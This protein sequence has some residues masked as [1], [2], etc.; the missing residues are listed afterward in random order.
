LVAAD[1]F[2]VLVP[3]H[4]MEFLSTLNR[5][6]DNPPQHRQ[7][8]RGLQQ[9]VDITNPQFN[10]IAGVQP[11]Y[12][13]NLLPEEAWGMGFMSRV[14]M[15]YSGEKVVVKLDLMNEAPAGVEHSARVKLLDR[16]QEIVD[17]E[18]RIL[19]TREANDA[20]ETWSLEG[21]KPVP[22][23]SKLEHYSA[24][25]LLHVIKL[26]I[27]ST[28]SR[29]SAIIDIV[30]FNRAK[31]WLLE[32]EQL[33]PD[34]FRE[35]VQRSDRQV[36]DELHWFAWKIYNKERSPIHET[37]LFEFLRIRAPADKIPRIIDIAVR[38][39]MFEDMGLKLY[40]PRPKHEHGVE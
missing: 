24:R 3:A 14:I 19:W 4:D 37:K 30:D 8:R 29:S 23:H 38:A 36:L 15:V 35:M 16:L 39:G 1:E 11:A 33:M 7:N 26:C 6:F 18:G 40:R 22:E 34:I 21:L 31:D 27:V 28:V 5:I 2:G 32:A 9:Q 10:I 17:I 25:R 20:I 12:L 13:A